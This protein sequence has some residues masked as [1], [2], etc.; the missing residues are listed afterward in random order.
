MRTRRT[1]IST[2]LAL[3][4]LGAGA[5]AF[6]PGC[7]IAGLAS[8]IGANIEKE[9]EVEVLAK[10]RGL[11]NRSVAV[12]AHTMMGTAYEFPTA[13]PNI[14]GNVANNIQQ[15]VQGSRVL[16][17]RHTVAWM[18]QHPGWPTM[19]LADLTNELDV[20][21]VVVI[22]VYEYRLNPEGNAFL[23][24][25]VAAANVGVAERDGIDPD[26][27][28]EE[29]QVISKFPDMEGIGREAAGAREVELGLQKTFVDEVAYLFYDHIEKKYPDRGIKR[30]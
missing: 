26:S 3:A 6:L 15:R 17:P 29:L 18:H 22:D 2:S 10:Y 25:G 5:I 8:A 11:E 23:W 1:T 14:V 4:A 28:A 30:K 12:L 16:D 20:D 24:D 19:P 27:Y 9:K 21:R 7:V 13:I